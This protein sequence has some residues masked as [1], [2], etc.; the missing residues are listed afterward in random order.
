[1]QRKRK[2][3]STRNADAIG[4]MNAI[5]IDMDPPQAIGKRQ[6]IIA[7]ESPRVQFDGVVLPP[8]QQ[9]PSARPIR[10]S[11][12]VAKAT[13]KKDRTSDLFLRLGQEFRALAKTCEELG[14]ALE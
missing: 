1:V 11:T 13:S 5:D 4:Q 9:K 7:S 3:Y 8:K 10:K 6:K 14:E 12:R 2:V